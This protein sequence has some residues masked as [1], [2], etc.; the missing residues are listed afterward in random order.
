MT[1]P[2]TLREMVILGGLALALGSCTIGPALTADEYAARQAHDRGRAWA[3]THPLDAPVPRSQ[4][5][6]ADDFQRGVQVAR[7]DIVWERTQHME[8]PPLPP[9]GT[10]ATPAPPRTNLE[11][12]NRTPPPDTLIRTSNGGDGGR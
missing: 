5:R 12:A 8:P 7:Q 9:Y 3:Q 10:P 1:T 6:Y 4:G 11:V 2:L